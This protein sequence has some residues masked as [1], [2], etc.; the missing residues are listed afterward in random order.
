MSRSDVLE[1]TYTANGANISRGGYVTHTLWSPGYG[2]EA[3]DGGRWSLYEITGPYS[4]RFVGRRETPEK[5]AAL[6]RTLVA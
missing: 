1:G 6:G 2:T 5:A 3:L 4:R